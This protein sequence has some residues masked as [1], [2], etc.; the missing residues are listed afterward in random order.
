MVFENY[1]RWSNLLTDCF[2]LGETILVIGEDF[3]WY[4]SVKPA[5]AGSPRFETLFLQY[6]C[7]SLDFREEGL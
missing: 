2:A 5:I 7:I 1:I 6:I 3:I 4:A